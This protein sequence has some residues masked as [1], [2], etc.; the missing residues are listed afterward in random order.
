MRGF[1]IKDILG[2]DILAK[3]FVR[4]Q[5][6]LLIMVAILLFG[7]IG[8][9]YYCEIQLKEELRLRKELKDL[10]YESLGISAELMQIS[11]RS[12]VLRMVNERGLGLEE[13]A[14]LPVKVE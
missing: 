5:Y 14:D 13:S 3:G 10:K 2:G 1:S 8:N 9:R 7:Y 6:P 4:R 11:R 12:N